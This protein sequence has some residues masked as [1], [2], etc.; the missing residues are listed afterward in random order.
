MNKKNLLRR[1]E[2]GG[3]NQLKNLKSLN[4]QKKPLM[5]C[6]GDGTRTRVNLVMSQDWDQLQPRRVD[7]DAA[8]IQP[9]H[10]CRKRNDVKGLFFYFSFF[11]WKNKVYIEVSYILFSCP[12]FKEK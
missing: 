8:K 6:S 3:P 12:L 1:G 2:A 11:S 5:T 7:F 4:Q 10:G 9:F